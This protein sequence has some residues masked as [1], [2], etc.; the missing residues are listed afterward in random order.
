MQSILKKR[1]ENIDGVIVISVR[2]KVHDS[3]GLC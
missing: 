3:R 1:V 2:D